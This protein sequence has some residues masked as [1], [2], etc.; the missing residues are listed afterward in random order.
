M[1]RKAILPASLAAALLALAAC[2]S[3]DNNPPSASNPPAPAAA[4]PS[5]QD[6]AQT[7]TPIKHLVVIY[8]ENRSFDHYFATYPQAKNT[9]GEP[10]F[11]ALAGTPVVKNLQT[12]NLIATN[13]NQT[14]A[15]NLAIT[16][17]IP[18]TELVPFRLDRAQANTADQS[19]SYSPE[20]E[21]SD[22]G[23]M[24]AFPAFTGKATMGSAGAFGTKAQVLGFFDGNTVTGLWNYAQH[25]AMSQNA[26]TDTYG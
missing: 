5:P 11:T 14:N 18:A 6:L 21:A 8:G 12:D 23:K 10:V 16:P 25:F 3:S 20:Q 4:A 19:H 9:P 1:F 15:S 17:A 24:D 2:G 7:A 26:Y 22:V 13:P